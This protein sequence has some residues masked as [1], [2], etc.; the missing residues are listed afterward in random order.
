MAMALVPLLRMR[1]PRFYQKIFLVCLSVLL[2]FGIV[3][4]FLRIVDATGGKV[5][6]V[7]SAQCKILDP[8]LVHTFVPLSS[9]QVKAAE[10]DISYKINPH[11]LRDVEHSWE[12]PKNTYRILIVGDSYTE[13]Q[14][15]ELEEIYGRI[16]E[17]K[18]NEQSHQ[19]VEVILAGIAGWSPLPEYIYLVRYGIKYQPDLV[20]IT[21]NTTDFSDE[22]FHESILTDEAKSLLKN[23]GDNWLKITKNNVDFFSIGS[24]KTV[25]Q[26]NI[27]L[28][29]R[30]K[31]F[32][33][34]N[35]K[36]FHFAEVAKGS[37]E[38]R[39]SQDEVKNNVM[40]ITQSKKPKDYQESFVRPEKNILRIKRLLEENN[41]SLLFV[42][43]PL[44]HIIGRDE[45]AKG[46]L[47]FGFKIGK[48]YSNQ[49]LEDIKSWAKAQAIDTFDLTA[50][51]SQA[52]KGS[53]QKLY[54]DFDGHW[55]RYGN[56]IVADALA[57][58]LLP[59]VN[60]TTN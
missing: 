27:S 1:L 9:C 30:F 7:E 19:K 20:I 57:D 38:R 26:Q 44:G 58:Y 55:T 29:A 2:A 56:Q 45:W 3:E 6:E 18:L 4:I 59:K 40:A 36:T 50:A 24:A 31:I 39:Y 13:G 16:L 52:K 23:T 37:F 14:G 60:K 25:N 5:D 53:S 34:A 47:E 43:F 11:S 32:L 17:N 42:V 48:T 15:V 54:F 12:K 35:F 21:F 33:T 28:I 8:I 22:Y 41:S 49:A 46:R 10:W 51:L